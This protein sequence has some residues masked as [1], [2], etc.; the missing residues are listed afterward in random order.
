MC[1][2]LWPHLSSVMVLHDGPTT[3]R[4]RLTEANTSTNQNL[5]PNLECIG[6]IAAVLRNRANGNAYAPGGKSSR[7]DG[8]VRV[9]S[10]KVYSE[11]APDSC[12][13]SLRFQTPGTT[14]PPR[15]PHSPGVT[16]TNHTKIIREVSSKLDICGHSRHKYSQN[17]TNLYTLTIYSWGVWKVLQTLMK[18]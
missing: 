12:R 10:Q 1:G 17:F 4:F 14:I 2:P 3:G 15:E 18:P 16:H 6:R 5:Y 13:R 7:C 8:W 11:R 9:H